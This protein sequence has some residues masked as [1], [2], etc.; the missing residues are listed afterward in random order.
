VTLNINQLHG[1]GIYRVALVLLGEGNI[2]FVVLNAM[3]VTLVVLSPTT[4][5][6]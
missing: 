4:K 3:T 5:V 6:E 2:T 1:K